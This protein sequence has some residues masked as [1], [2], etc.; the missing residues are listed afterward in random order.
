MYDK[1]PLYITLGF[2][3]RSN[4]VEF[5]SNACNSLRVRLRVELQK[6]DPKFY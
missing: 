2:A 1:I 5:V 6:N 4:R 3:L